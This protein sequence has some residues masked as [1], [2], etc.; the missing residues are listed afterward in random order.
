MGYVSSLVLLF[1]GSFLMKKNCTKD[2][3]LYA[4]KLEIGLSS[5]HLI[6]QHHLTIN[7]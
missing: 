4:V 7:I 3:F 5:P 1:M 6:S 2:G